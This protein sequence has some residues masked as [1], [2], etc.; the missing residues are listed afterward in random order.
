MAFDDARHLEAGHVAA[1]AGRGRVAAA[2]LHEVCAVERAGVHGDEDLLGA[3]LR[4]GELTNLE[5]I[6]IAGLTDDGRSHASILS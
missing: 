3:G 1:D 4:V 6:G 5:D 2:P